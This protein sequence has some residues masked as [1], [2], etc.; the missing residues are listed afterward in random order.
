MAAAADPIV[1]KIPPEERPGPEPEEPTDDRPDWMPGGGFEN[2][3]LP[4]TWLNE[5]F[6]EIVY[7]NRDILILID[8]KDADRGT[9][10]TIASLQLAAGMDQTDE[11]VT[12]D[13]AFIEPEQM[14]NAY[15]EQPPGSALVLDEAEIGAG[16][17]DTQSKTNKAISQIVSTGRVEQKYVIA[18]LPAIEMIDLNLRKMAK[19]WIMMEGRGIGLVHH[20]R[21]EPYSGKLLRE[22]KQRL[23]MEDI[24]ADNPVRDVYQYLTREK[25]KHIR[26]ERGESF[27][28]KDEHE[29]EK[30]KAVEETEKSVRDELIQRIYGHGEIEVSQRVLAEAVGLSESQVGN[31]TRGET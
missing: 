22:R 10:K 9:G 31:I 27:I 13:K 19:V 3:F 4:E 14:L 5:E 26:G 24:P 29:K 12:R 20:L 6:R 8:D 1:E 17:R 16:H 25:K 18:N 30:S 23:E 28:P 21:R 2:P 11:G 15:Y 7:Q